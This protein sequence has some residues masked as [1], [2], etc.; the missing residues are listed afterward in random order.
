MLLLVFGVVLSSTQAPCPPDAIALMEE[1]AV[2]A[3]EFDLAGAAD[4][5]QIATD[6]GCPQ[7]EVGALYLRGLVDA[8]QAFRQGGG[9]ASL[10]PVRRAIA[11]LDALAQNRPGPAEIARLTLHA[12]AAAAQ[13]ERDEMR[14]YL[15]SAIAMESLQRAAGQAGAPV[16]TAAETAGDLWLQVYQYEDA[17]RVYTDAAAQA[18]MTPRI[19]AG[20]ARAAARLNDAAA[21]CANYRTLLGRWSARQVEPPE[22]IE[23]RGYLMQPACEA[24]SQDRPRPASQ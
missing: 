20:L 12:A 11:S 8:R 4:R 22:I 16:V 24:G 2:R 23:A 9:P 17:R 18:G 3:T 7:A 10:A 19:T 21:A 13:S 6:A 15:S 1:A 14:V 5:L